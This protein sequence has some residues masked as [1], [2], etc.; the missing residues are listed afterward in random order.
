MS[1]CRPMVGGMCATHGNA[2]SECV[3]DAAEDVKAVVN[4]SHTDCRTDNGVAVGL[5]D[6]IISQVRVLRK[7]YEWEMASLGAKAALADIASDEDILWLLRLVDQEAEGCGWCKHPNLR[8][9]GW[10][11]AKCGGC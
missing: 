3:A 1:E 2:L 4:E 5:L 7:H 11:C 6:G 9:D 10:Y 8:I